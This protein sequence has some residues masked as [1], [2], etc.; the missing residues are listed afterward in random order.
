MRLNRVK[1]VAEM[2]RQDLTIKEMAKRTGL[3]GNTIGFVRRGSSCTY[4]TATAIA[5]ALGVDVEDLV[6]E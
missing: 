2:A 3:S 4:E 1:V 6:E 5:K